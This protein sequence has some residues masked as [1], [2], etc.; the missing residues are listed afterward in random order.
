MTKPARKRTFPQRP[1]GFALVVTISLMVL[2]SLLAVGLLGLSTVSLRAS[3]QQQDMQMARANARLAL[4]I[5]IGQLQ[6]RVGADQRITAPARLGDSSAPAQLTGVWEGVALDS[7]NP[8]VDASDHFLGY[9]SSGIE[10]DPRQLPATGG[11]T[12]VG[13]NAFGDGATADEIVQAPLVTVEADTGS[14]KRGGFAWAAFDE[15]A[16]AKINLVRDEHE[17]LDKPEIAA[18]GSASRFGLETLDG[19]DDFD[20]FDSDEQGNLATLGSGKLLGLPDLAEYQHD[21]TVFSRGLLTDAA[22]GGLKQ[23]LSRLFND[24]SLPADWR[25]RRLYSDAD[26]DREDANPYWSHLASY[27]N[28]YREI[29]EQRGGGYQLAATASV[30]SSPRLNRRDGAYT[31]PVAPDEAPL[32]P[33]VSKVEL[34]FTLVAKDAHGHWGGGT[35]V[36]RTGDSRRKY[37]LYMIYSPIVTLYNPYDVPLEVNGMKID[38]ADVPIGFKFYRNGQAQT[39]QMAHFN[40][41]YVYHDQNSQKAKAFGLNLKPSYNSSARTTILL[42]P[43]ESLVFG[44]SVDGG[45]S[46]NDGG[47]FD[48]QD[49]LTADVTLAP[50][51]AKGMGFWVDWLT[52]DHMLTAA[53]DGMGIFSIRSTDTVDVEFGPMGSDA[54]QNRLAID[55][56]LLSGG[57]RAREVRCG[58]FFLSYND[59][60]NPDG[61]LEETIAPQG[62]TRLQ[63][64]KRVTEIYQ[65]PSDKIRDYSRVLP[66]ATFTFQAKTTMGSSTPAK[67]WVQGSNATNMA[68]IRLEEDKG[69][70]SSHEVKLRP[71][72]KPDDYPWD[73]LTNRAYFFTSADAE[74]GVLAAP[75][76]EAPALPLQSIAQL[77]HS[78]LAPQGFAWSPGYTVGESFASPLIPAAK[79]VADGAARGPKL[80]DHTWLANNELWDRYFF[81]TLTDYAGPVMGSTRQSAD[82]AQGFFSGSER[83]LNPRLVPVSNLPASE[84]TSTVT[85]AESYR[86]IAAHMMIDGPFNVNS[87]SVEAWKSVLAS[88][89][90]EDV[91]Y[92]DAL[93][94]QEG[95]KSGADNPFTRTR[96]ATGPPV[97]DAA[98]LEQERR[99]A[100]WTGFRTLGDSELEGLAERIVEEVRER[101]PFLSFA[102]FVN[103]RP[104]SDDELAAKGAIQAA[105]DE[106]NINSEFSLDGPTYGAADMGDAGFAFPEAIYGASAAGAPG[107]LTQGDILSSV[108]QIMT[109]RSDTFRIRTYGQAVDAAGRVTARAWCEAVVQRTPDYVDDTDEAEDLPTTPANE[110]FGRRF[111]IT[112]FRWLAP[113]EV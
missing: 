15:S 99:G 8:S 73:P 65:S 56:T 110:N 26:L 100:R 19:L 39:T 70:N 91:A 64:P 43:G 7:G 5:A 20:W 34:Q 68:V 69:V 106:T 36:S 103:R 22:R 50:G 98:G 25:S 104:G 86:S 112:A 80:L 13:E 53:D 78:R 51:Y 88:M 27:A 14:N 40:Q 102:D 11:V 82:I 81:S 105:I 30:S 60:R 18:L 87:L 74:T 79:V 37:M 76:F 1:K 32:T 62:V 67:P 45:W 47:M 57:R 4:N 2:L 58:Q 38:F 66:F 72:E 111:V 24:D 16:K 96:R 54:S 77:R 84:V 101:G 61:L 71:V 75:Q 49:N 109:V 29:Q 63:R 52:P 85:D 107:Y 59:R 108:G 92:L 31:D 3:G 17:D 89:N 35:I 9:L 23:D 95:T 48:W 12:L 10:S 28:T 83:L 90:N 41:L 46:W 55:V 33:V 44:E 113:E 6:K 97:E 21:L 42:E 93:T 94:G